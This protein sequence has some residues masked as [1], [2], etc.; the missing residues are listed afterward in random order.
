[1]NT[2]TYEI[3][4]AALRHPHVTVD[5]WGP[6]WAGYDRS[7]PLSE[8]V[9]RRAWRIAQLEESKAEHSRRKE[10]WWEY[11]MG[12]YKR[13]MR[14]QR[15]GGDAGK[16]QGVASGHLEKPREWVKPGWVL[17][18]V[19]TPG[20]AA[21]LSA[22]EGGAMAISRERSEEGNEGCHPTVQF[23]VAWTISYVH[24]AAFPLP[25]SERSGSQ[26]HMQGHLQTKRSSCGRSRL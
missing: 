4:D 23:D 7:V 15:D 3:V 19:L 25:A 14:G 10:G 11:E 2:H 5:V 16:G 8:N 26:A 22:D 13:K 21:A 17:K 9:R 12:K 20:P 18:R 1:M 24:P 6:G